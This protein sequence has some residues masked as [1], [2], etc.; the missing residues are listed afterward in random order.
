M[1]WDKWSG[2]GKFMSL[3]NKTS[4]IIVTYNHAKYMR[5]CISSVLK[6]TPSEV[7]VV[8]NGSSDGTVELIEKEFPQVKLIRSP[9][10]LGYGG[11]NNFGVKHA[12][13]EYIAL[14]NPDTKVEENWLEELLKSLENE[15]KLI[16]T[17][18]ILTYDGSKI[19]TCGNIDHFTGLTFTRGLNESPEKFNEFEYLSGLSGACF[20]M[21]RKDYLELGG[22]DEN[23]LTYMEDAE[24]SWRA[25]AKG[26]KILYVPTSIVYHDYEL[27]VP[28]KK[29]YHLE[30]G[31]YIILRKYLT[32]REFLLMLPS[33][34]ATETLTWGYSILNQIEGVRFKIKGMKDGITAKVEKINCDR[35]K[36]LKSLDWKIPEEQLSYSMLDRIIKKIANFV[37]WIN[38]KVITR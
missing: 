12:K 15:K 20:A 14:L 32:W 33:L 23:F 25:H 3:S 8:D 2:G 9:R 28:S 26:F 38:Y 6:N 31:R 13:G 27:K 5:N 1:F 22:F 10:N 11:G 37:Y 4:V 17:P 30:K 24:F 34:L 29:I 7:I 21:R 19:N 35:K 18:K 36:L 16:T